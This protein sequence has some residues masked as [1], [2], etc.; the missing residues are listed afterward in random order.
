MNAHDRGYFLLI[1]A[2]YKRSIVF[3]SRKRNTIL[4][5]VKVNSVVYV[6]LLFFNNF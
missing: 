4:M 3:D 5:S 1:F 2:I 6:F